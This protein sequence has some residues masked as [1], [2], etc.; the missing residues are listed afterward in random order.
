LNHG[1]RGFSPWSLGL[2]ALG[3]RSTWQRK[4]VN[5]M[6]AVRDKKEKSE[7]EKEERRETEKVLE[8]QYPH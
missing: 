5:L 3:L 6:I 2:V 7:E 4:A 8:F 1:F